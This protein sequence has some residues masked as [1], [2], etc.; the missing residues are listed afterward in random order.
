MVSAMDP[1]WGSLYCVCT[2]ML[3]LLT[4]MYKWV[5]LQ[6]RGEEMQWKQPQYVLFYLFIYLFFTFI[7]NALEPSKT[8]LKGPYSATPLFLFTY[9]SLAITFY[10]E[11]IEAK[12]IAVKLL[13]IHTFRAILSGTQLNQ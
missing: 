8:P 6:E 7:P 10:S 4:Q 13:N 2:L 12:K 1:Y 3:P 5:L 11:H 9:M